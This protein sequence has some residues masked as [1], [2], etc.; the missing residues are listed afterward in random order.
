MSSLEVLEYHLLLYLFQLL[1]VVHILLYVDSLLHVQNEHQGISLTMLQ[2]NSHLF[3]VDIVLSFLGP[4][5]WHME[6]PRLGVKWELQLLAYPIAIATPELSHICSLQ[7]SSWQWQILNPLSEARDWTHIPMDTS[8]ICDCS[9]TA[10]TPYIFF[11][12]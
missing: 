6:V 3:F 4:C 7:H 11:W 1:E 2:K 10:G 8:R 12:L 9:A 5:L